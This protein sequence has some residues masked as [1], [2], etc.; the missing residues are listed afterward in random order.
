MVPCRFIPKTCT[1]S[2]SNTENNR[3]FKSRLCV[4]KYLPFAR[5]LTFAP[6]TG[7]QSQGQIVDKFTKAHKAEAHA[8]AH[9]A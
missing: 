7:G 4:N 1:Q 6:Y 2:I 8:K 5:D 3:V 9:Q